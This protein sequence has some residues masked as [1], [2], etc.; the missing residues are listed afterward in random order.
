MRCVERQENH[1]EQELKNIEKSQNNKEMRKFRLKERT[2]KAII[3]EELI[4]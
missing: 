1:L 4:T 2:A 3:K